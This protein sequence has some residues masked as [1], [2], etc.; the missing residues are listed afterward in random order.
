MEIEEK[1][2]KDVIVIQ[3][4]ISH[5][6]DINVRMALEYLENRRDSSLVV[7]NTQGGSVEVVER[8]SNALRLFY[9]SVDFLIPHEAM[10]AGTV[11]ALS[12][13]AIWMDNFSRLGPIDPQVLREG[14]FVPG[15]SYQHQYN[16]LID[17]SK[18]SGLTEAELTLLNKLD[19]AELHQIQLAASLSASLIRE[20]LPKYNFKNWNTHKNGAPV[21]ERDKTKQAEDIAKKLND[22]Q[23][24]GTHAR[25]IHMGTLQDLGLRIDDFRRVAGLNELI[26]RYFW[27]MVEYVR[28]VGYAN[29][30]QSRRFI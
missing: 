5:G 24:W 8:I 21:L 16:A 22:N 27:G 1:M 23:W 11:L 28:R 6:L 17:K 10:S 25:G 19:L 7:L 12:G 14:R 9:E 13:D 20:W 3:G 18:K 29:F 30:V 2:D 26:W 15:L 4:V